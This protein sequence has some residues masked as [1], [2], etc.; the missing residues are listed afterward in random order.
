[1]AGRLGMNIE[2]IKDA[3]QAL[4]K[5]VFTGSKRGAADR[6][7]KVVKRLAKK[8]LGNEDARLVSDP[9][10]ACNTYVLRYNL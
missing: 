9:H 1:M 5:E 8:Y 7:E 6:L 3:Y 2:E 10:S 4:A